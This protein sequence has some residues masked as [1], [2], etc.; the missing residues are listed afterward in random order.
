[1]VMGFYSGSSGVYGQGELKR[2][3]R[4]GIHDMSIVLQ[5][6]CKGVI[7]LLVRAAISKAPLSNSIEDGEIGGGV[8]FRSCF[9]AKCKPSKHAG[10]EV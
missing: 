9:P 1:M 5:D 4:L 3:H 10:S 6:L 7:Q 8:F 2:R